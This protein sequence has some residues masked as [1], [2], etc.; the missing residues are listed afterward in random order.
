[1]RHDTPR[2]ALAIGK[3]RHLGQPV[4][5]VIAETLL[6]AQ[7]AA[8]AIQV[9]YETLPAVTDGRAAL[10]NDAP[11]LFDSIPGNLVFDWDN[12]TSD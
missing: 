4:A 10:E 7:D 2:P 1:P 6:Q 8:E 9:D 5:L 11:Q 3:V 12:D